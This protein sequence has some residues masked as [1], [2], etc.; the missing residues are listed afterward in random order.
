MLMQTCPWLLLQCWKNIKTIVND[1]YHS[2]QCTTLEKTSRNIFKEDL[3]LKFKLY[4]SKCNRNNLTACYC[5]A[6]LL[7]FLHLTGLP[8]SS[9]AFC[10]NKIIIQKKITHTHTHKHLYL[11]RIRLITMT[12]VEF[13][14]GK[15]DDD[16]QR[17]YLHCQWTITSKKHIHYLSLKQQVTE[18]NFNTSTEDVFWP[19]TQYH[20]SAI[21]MSDSLTYLYTLIPTRGVAPLK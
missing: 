20:L 11:L 18:L 15:Q 2:V 3:A 1:S 13:A 7:R 4:N 19:T 8:N 10:F 16:H 9:S 17:I 5:W 6:N 14:I 21:L 12:T